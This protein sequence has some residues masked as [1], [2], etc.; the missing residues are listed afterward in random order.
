MVCGILG[1]FWIA[2]NYNLMFIYT[3]ELF[4]TVVRNAAL[5]RTSLAAQMGA[6]LAPI[7]VVLGERW[8]FVVFAGCG[9]GGGSVCIFFA[10]DSKPTSL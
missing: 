2:G 9:I 7:V 3:T 1:I 8:P 10:S 4:P 6:M 5:G